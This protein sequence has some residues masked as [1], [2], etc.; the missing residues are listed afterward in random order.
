MVF[1]HYPVF[2]KLNI[3]IFNV[4]CLLEA[5][6]VKLV[7]RDV[8]GEWLSSCHVIDTMGTQATTEE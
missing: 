2:W 1:I 8:A 7:E 3:C 5:I 6:I 4:V